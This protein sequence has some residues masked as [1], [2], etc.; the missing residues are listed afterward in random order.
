MA[1]SGLGP[2]G[3]RLAPPRLAQIFI[4]LLA[5]SSELLTAFGPWSLHGWGGTILV[6]WGGLVKQTWQGLEP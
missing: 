1:E 3:E 2:E 5:D 4:Q 6:A